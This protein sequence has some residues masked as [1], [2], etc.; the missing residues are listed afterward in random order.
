VSTLALLGGSPTLNAPFRPYM[1]IGAEERAAV[2]RV[3]SSG[4]LSGFIGAW[5][6]E[7][8]GGPEIVKFEA[9]WR[10]KFGVKHAISVNSNTSGMIAAMGAV[11]VGPGDE[12]IVP[13]YTMSA[14]AMA[15]LFYGGI[16]VFADV[17]S[18]TYCLDVDSV[19]AA[20][21]PRTRAILVVNLFGHAAKLHE[22]RALA[23][24]HGLKLVEDN[25]QSPLATERGRYTGAIGHIGVFSLNYHKHFHTG[26]GGVCI[27][28]DDDLALRLK[29]IRNH[30]EN[31]VE[32][33]NVTDLTNIVGFNFRMTELSAAIGVE[34]LGKSDRLVAGREAMANR[35]SEGLRGLPGL[36][37]PVVREDC[38]HVY[39]VWGARYDAS[40]TGVSRATLAKALNAEGVPT[41]EGYVQPLYMLPLFQKR[42]AIGRQGFPFN[43]TNRHYGP[44]L[45]PVTEKLHHE[46][47][48]EFW[49]CSFDLSDAE[50]QST[51]DAYHKV[52]ENLPAL[53]DFERRQAQA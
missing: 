42:V 14:T 6:D 52:F 21:T 17:D 38:R 26:E 53:A 51:I 12:V 9:A 3:M 40:K 20:I 30:G 8:G 29:M 50:L 31:L 16:P 43:L 44:G 15:P 25:A 18:E 13:P 2:D 5:C 24:E 33:L 45:C 39:Y 32:P 36:S 22:L 19:R 1:T 34:Q 46:Q 41:G 27:T 37:V 23:D 49:I 35:L 47:M 10:T 4:R 11:G 28:D 7:F 48:L